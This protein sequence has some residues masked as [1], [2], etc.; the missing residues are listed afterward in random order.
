MAARTVFTAGTQPVGEKAERMT[1]RERL[2][3]MAGLAATLLPFTPAQAD[4]QQALIPPDAVTTAF[5]TGTVP[6]F[7][8][9]GGAPVPTASLLTT[10]GTSAERYRRVLELDP[11]H[12][13]ARARLDPVLGGA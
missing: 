3:R 8:A 13:H 4:A 5:V 6:G 9:V 7:G 11:G 12:A 2:A 1:K 10:A